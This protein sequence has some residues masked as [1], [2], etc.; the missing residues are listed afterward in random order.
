MNIQVHSYGHTNSDFAF[1]HAYEGINEYHSS[2][3]N[4]WDSSFWQTMQIGPL[5]IT[6][7]T[8]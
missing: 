8:C 2:L 3:I 4:Q 1:E 5:Y 7:Q 6:S